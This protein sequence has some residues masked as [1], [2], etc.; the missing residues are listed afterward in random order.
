MAVASRSTDQTSPTV[1]AASTPNR[2]AGQP[3]RCSK[4]RSGYQQGITRIGR[5]QCLG[6]LVLEPQMVVQVPSL[7]WA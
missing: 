5:K 6:E 3:C 1:K 2:S 4:Q 7:F